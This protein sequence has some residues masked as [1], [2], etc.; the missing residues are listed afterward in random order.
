MRIYLD[1]NAT[2]PLHSAVGEAL[3]EAFR[4]VYGNA[5]SV[6]QEGRGARQALEQARESVAG[7]IGAAPR[8]VIYQRRNGIE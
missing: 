4:D 6:H 7:L 8:E 3:Q 1:N 5:S 2:T